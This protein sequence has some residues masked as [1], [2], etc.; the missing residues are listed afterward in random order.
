MIL[1]KGPKNYWIR[2]SPKRQSFPYTEKWNITNLF[3]EFCARLSSTSVTRSQIIFLIYLTLTLAILSADITE[4]APKTQKLPLVVPVSE[5]E[6]GVRTYMEVNIFWAGVAVQL[7][8]MIAIL[9]KM[10][11]DYREK[12][13]D[14]TADA[15]EENNDLL[16]SLSTQVQLL[17]QRI[18]DIPKKFVAKED[19]D[20]AIQKK[21]L[22]VEQLKNKRSQ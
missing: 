13:N 21:I 7:I 5:D 9:A 12:K 1:K 8:G 10:I 14:K 11:W 6:N 16:R 4:A 19:L 15:L 2:S 17:N 20:E 18:D 3:R 22:F